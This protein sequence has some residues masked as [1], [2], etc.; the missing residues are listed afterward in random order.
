MEIL[1]PAVRVFSSID[2]HVGL[3]IALVGKQASK[4]V[5]CHR[6]SQTIIGSTVLVT[7]FATGTEALS[8]C[9]LPLE[10]S[11]SRKNWLNFY[12]LE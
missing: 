10:E 2:M 6:M 7:W 12:N 4:I 1:Q 11:E 9:S 3:C 5:T 8:L